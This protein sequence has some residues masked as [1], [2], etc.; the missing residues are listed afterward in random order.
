MIVTLKIIIIKLIFIK[1]LSYD[2]F[3]SI[4]YIYISFVVL[5]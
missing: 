3:N 4:D 1:Y 5:S 2:G